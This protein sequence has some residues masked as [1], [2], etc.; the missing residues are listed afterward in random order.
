MLSK[1]HLIDILETR[2]RILWGLRLYVVFLLENMCL[3]MS[4]IVLF[5]VVFFHSET[6]FI[7]Q[8][9][10]KLSIPCCG[11]NATHGNSAW[12]IDKGN[13]PIA[14][15]YA[16]N[17]YRCIM[18]F[19]CMMICQYITPL[20]MYH[21]LFLNRLSIDHFLQ[22]VDQSINKWPLNHW[23]HLLMDHPT[24]ASKQPLSIYVRFDRKTHHRIVCE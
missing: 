13:Q 7:G 24:D 22:I 15:I 12:L 4:N 21:S 18:I 5:V 10:I 6:G 11:L 14:I 19:E 16:T 9:S 17:E 3:N 8:L 2:C 23:N 1:Y 20:S